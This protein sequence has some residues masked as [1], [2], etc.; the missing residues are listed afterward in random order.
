LSAASEQPAESAASTDIPLEI[1]TELEVVPPSVA[2]PA[3]VSA[4][5]ARLVQEK[6]EV[7][8]RRR[9]DEIMARAELALER[10]I[11][12]QEVQA[13]AYDAREEV[14][15]QLADHEYEDLARVQKMRSEAKDREQD[16][17]KRQKRTELTKRFV[18]KQNVVDRAM[19][20]EEMRLQRI[21]EA[22]D[23]ADAVA[24]RK[25]DWADRRAVHEERHAQARQ[26]KA[27][28]LMH[29]L[30]AS[31]FLH[32]QKAQDD[33]AAMEAQRAAVRA[34]RDLRGRV[35][36]ARAGLQH[37]SLPQPELE[38][39]ARTLEQFRLFT[40][41]VRADALDAR[42][43]L[44]SP[45]AASSAASEVTPRPP[46]ALTPTASPEPSPG[47]PGRE[48]S[49]GPDPAKALPL[50]RVETLLK[51]A[52]P[53]SGGAAFSAAE[54]IGAPA[55]GQSIF[56][57]LSVARQ[58]KEPGAERSVD[59]MLGIQKKSFYAGGKEPSRPRPPDL[60]RPSA[61]SASGA[62]AARARTAD[63]TVRES[64]DPTP[65]AV[66]VLPQMPSHGAAALSRIRRTNP[67]HRAFTPR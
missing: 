1:P 45:R 47:G 19:R 63:P 27:K 57:A 31:R 4:L 43:A 7:T 52:L 50:F 64:W 42:G 56:S 44:D 9:N 17:K 59:R 30:Q 28:D 12:R 53:L 22:D 18:V 20:S 48:S 49:Y 16:K 54:A 29:Q 36:D 35:L 26:Q 10:D 25:A 34:E 60:P 24:R 40:E 5:R 65:V 3:D 33:A 23:I 55:M 62:P 11:E 21:K 66:P 6:R 61:V 58:K 41:D 32:I 67:R 38:E 37:G 14:L 2:R 15:Q 39:Y 13:A 8:Q 46:S 51:D